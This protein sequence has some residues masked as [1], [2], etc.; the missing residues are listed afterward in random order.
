[1]K[2]APRTSSLVAVVSILV[3]LYSQVPAH[4]GAGTFSL[5]VVRSGNGHG[6]V[7][8]SPVGID[9]GATCTFAFAPGTMVTLTATAA[10]GK[11]FEGWMGA[12]CSGTGTCQVT[13]DADTTVKALFRSDHRPDAWINWCGSGD[14]CVGAPPHPWRGNNVYNM[15]GVHQTFPAGVEEG[16]DIRFWIVLENDGALSDTIYVKGC[17]GNPS[18]FIRDVN[19]GK[20]RRSMDRPVITA[21]WKNGTAHFKFGPADSAKLKILTLDIWVKTSVFNASYT[22]P[23]TIHSASDPTLKDHVVARMTTT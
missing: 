21:Q 22:C 4:A 8:S 10:A 12:G 11:V 17:A 16:N 14:T 23:I 19:I 13:M 18:F 15:T 9:C 7:S 2:R 1:V 6:S 5:T 3:A 20:L